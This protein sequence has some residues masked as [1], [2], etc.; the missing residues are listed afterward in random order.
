MN[1]QTVVTRV[2]NYLPHTDPRPSSGLQPCGLPSAGRRAVPLVSSCARHSAITPSAFGAE[3]H[4]Y[5]FAPM[6]DE[7]ATSPRR[8]LRPALSR[9]NDGP[10]VV[11]F[12]S[13]NI[14]NGDCNRTNVRYIMIG[15]E[16]D[17]RDEWIWL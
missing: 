4:G 8:I 17:C 16:C 13:S 6:T 9:P 10:V 15:D 14:A 11:V 1:L 12:F 2:G 3:R 7:G 5:I